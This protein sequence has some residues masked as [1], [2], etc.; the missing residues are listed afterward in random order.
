MIIDRSNPYLV[1][2][3]EATEEV[4]FKSLAF[5]VFVHNGLDEWMEF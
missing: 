1:E 2:S 5:C 3:I 4:T